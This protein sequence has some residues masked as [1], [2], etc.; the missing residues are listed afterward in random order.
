YG[1]VDGGDQSVEPVAL[2]LQ[3]PAMPRQHLCPGVVTPRGHGGV[4]VFEA[5]AQVAQQEDLLQLEQILLP[6]VAPAALRRPS[7]LEE[8]DSVVV[9][10]GASCQAR[11]ACYFVDRPTHRDPSRRGAGR[12]APPGARVR[13]PGRH[14]DT[15]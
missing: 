3:L 8:T 15:G 6:V 13:K 12:A 9:P 2:G 7:G 1:P 14:E 10:E 5:Q 11:E 4:D